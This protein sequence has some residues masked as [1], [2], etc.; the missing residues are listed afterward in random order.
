[1]QEFNITITRNWCKEDYIIGRLFL[2]DEFLCNTLEDPDRGLYQDESKCSH[3]KI[4][5]DT[6]IPYGRYKLVYRYSPRF[7]PKYGVWMPAL[8][9]V[10]HFEGILIHP[11]NTKKDTEG[12]I[13]VGENKSVGKVL[14]SQYWFSQFNQKVRPIFDS[15]RSIYVTIKKP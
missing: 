10:N 3:M 4:K 1:M 6:C 13:L 9:D 5:G 11:G 2:E 15:G 8:T 14:R 7:S 12:C